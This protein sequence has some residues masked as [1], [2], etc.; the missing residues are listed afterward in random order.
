MMTAT[1]LPI[2]AMPWISILAS[3]L[4]RPVMVMRALP[5]KLSPNISRRIWV[6]RSP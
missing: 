1:L 3:G 2:T 5:G 6:S 4:A